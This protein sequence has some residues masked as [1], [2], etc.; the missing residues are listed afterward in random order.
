MDAMGMT[1]MKQSWPVVLI[2]ALEHTRT[3]PARQIA[4]HVALEGTALLVMFH[5]QM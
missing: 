4:K 2:V 1:Q 5:L 3:R